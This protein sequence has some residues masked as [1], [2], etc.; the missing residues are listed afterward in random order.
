VDVLVLEAGGTLILPKSNAPDELGL[1]LPADVV[2]VTGA[3]KSLGYVVGA[4]DTANVLTNPEF[5]TYTAGTGFGGTAAPD[6]WDI[7][8]SGT[9]GTEWKLNVS[10]NWIVATHVTLN[11][12]RLRQLFSAMPFTQG[13]FPTGTLFRVKFTV[14]GLSAGTVTPHISF[15]PG[16]P[17]SA[18]GINEEEIALADTYEWPLEVSFVPSTDFD[19]NIYGIEVE[20]VVN[21]LYLTEAVPTTQL[22]QKNLSV[23]LK[24]RTT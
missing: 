10:G 11:V 7:E 13:Q 5:R 2:Q 3:G 24:E 20:P 15:T 9:W 8:P 21:S 19:G 1:F 18:N 16:T 6:D 22:D 14:A 17:V 23:R 4:A 12:L